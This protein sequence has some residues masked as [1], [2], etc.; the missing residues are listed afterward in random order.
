MPTFNS[1]TYDAQTGGNPRNRLSSAATNAEIRIAEIEYKVKGTEAAGDILKLYQ[2]QNGV[3]V[4]T[5]LSAVSSEGIGGT[6]VTLT[7]IGDAADDDRYS[8]AAVAL[9]AAG[10]VPLTVIPANRAV[11]WVT[12]GTSNVI[13][14]TLGGTLPATAGKRF[15]LKLAYRIS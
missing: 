5:E 10:F 15:W 1:E 7:K 2:I 6:G 13:Q 3:V 12:D 8:T 4:Y 9:T 14:A 11:P